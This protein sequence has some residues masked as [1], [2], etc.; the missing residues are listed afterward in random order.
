MKPPGTEWVTGM[1]SH[2]NGPTLKRSPSRTSRSSA[3]SSR[4]A[5]ASLCRT[6]P[7]VNADPYTGNDR[8][9]SRY[10]RAPMWSSWAWVATQASTPPLASSHLKS[11]STESTPG[12]SSP[13]NIRPQ[14]S[15]TLRPAVSMT[16]Q[17]R[18]ISPRPPRKVTAT[19]AATARGQPDPAGAG[20]AGTPAR[21]SAST[22]GA[23]SGDLPRAPPRRRPARR[24]PPWPGPPART[25]RV[26]WA[27]GTAPRAAPAPATC[28]WWAPGWGRRRRSRSHRSR[29]AGG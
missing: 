18:P 23:G 1:A 14:S 2:S 19:G 12:R 20:S 26:P 17:L 3:R 5:S 13:A 21:G 10:G 9:S 28:T 15:S 6:R 16:A 29:A 7:S 22:S 27:G 8:R 24:A 25:A 4:P 11:G